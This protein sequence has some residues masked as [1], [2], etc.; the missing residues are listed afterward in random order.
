MLVMPELFEPLEARTLLSADVE[1]CSRG[2]AH[3]VAGPR[4]LEATSPT[5]SGATVAARSFGAADTRQYAPAKSGKTRA[6]RVQAANVLRASSNGRYLVQADGSPFFYM[7][8]TAWH[9]L[10]KLSRSDADRYLE[11]RAVQG[12]T[13]IQ[14]EI[15]TR[16]RENVAGKPFLGDNPSR[17]N[18][19][20][21]RHVD[22]VIGKANA[23]GM[24]VSLVPLD[25]RWASRGVFTPETAYTFGRYLGGRYQTSK[26]IWTLGGDIGGDEVPAGPTL[27]RELAAGVARGAAGRDMSKVMMQFHPG[28]GQSSSRWFQ[29]DSWLDMNA[30]Q[31][32]HSMNPGN[33]NTVASEYGRSPTRPVMDI[34][35]GYEDM[36]AGIVA[37][38]P[39][40]T[41]YD[42]RKAQYWALFAGAHGVTFGNNNVWQFVR[43]LSS[44]NLATTTWQEALESPGANSM[45]VLKRLMLSRPYLNR[46]PDQ[47]VIVGSALSG[48]DHLRATRASDGSY[49]FVYSASGQPV[50]VNLGK[51]S[52]TQVTARWFNPRN[53]RSSVVGTFAKSGNRTFTAPAAGYD[54]VLILD[55]AGRQFGKP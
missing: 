31:S 4:Q 52:G 55:D 3:A 15:N 40:L 42:V 39:R 27:W 2:H 9:L 1:L 34:E 18:E 13:V 6:A 41:D 45:A 36:P 51:L 43:T 17:P 29:N 33:Y 37:G 21:F 32:G 14:M 46:V 12:F 11:T 10:N 22:Y 38:N 26:V 19:A 20:F 5:Q 50:T 53:G 16:F 49:A 24:Y 7:A 44:R 28:Y 47:S 48:K 54:W 25:T 23:L 8:D 35:P 30:F